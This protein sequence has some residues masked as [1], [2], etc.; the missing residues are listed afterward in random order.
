MP[1]P[2]QSFCLKDSGDFLAGMA[3]DIN[4]ELWKQFV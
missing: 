4:L 3:T 2:G 1:V